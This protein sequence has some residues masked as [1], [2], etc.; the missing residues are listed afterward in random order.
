MLKTILSDESQ[1]ETNSLVHV[2]RDAQQSQSNQ[3]LRNLLLSSQAR[4]FSRPQLLIYADDVQCAE[5]IVH[6]GA[7]TSFPERYT[8]A[9]V[10][11]VNAAKIDKVSGNQ[12]Y[13]EG[14]KVLP[15]GR[16]YKDPF[17]RRFVR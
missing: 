2:V 8:L 6:D 10:D 4:V 12:V 14:D 5:A 13:L 16:A 9:G 15:I 3:L 11:I 7:N 17:I 1:A